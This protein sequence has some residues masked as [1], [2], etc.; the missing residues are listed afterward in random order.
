MGK[1]NFID[2][3]CDNNKRNCIVEPWYKNRKYINFLL[4]FD[5]LLSDSYKKEIKKTNIKHKLFKKGIF[6]SNCKRKFYKLYKKDSSSFYIPNYDIMKKYKKRKNKMYKYEI[7]SV[8][9]VECIRLDDII[10]KIK[11]NFDFI[12]IDVQ[13]DEYNVIK[14][15][16]KYLDTQI[17]G[18][19]VEVN[20]VK[21]YKDIILGEKVNR[22][23]NQH[24]FYKYKELGGVPRMSEDYLYIKN[25]KDKE[26]KIE[27]IK[28]VYKV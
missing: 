16:G 21:N 15:L 6:S 17:V 14:S 12:K 13:G 5:P 19:C 23:L 22:L 27:L 18:I 1:I 28:K 26:N 10:D 2:V 3:G 20:Y 7:K 8:D 11:M 24:N 9:I 4:G 25:D